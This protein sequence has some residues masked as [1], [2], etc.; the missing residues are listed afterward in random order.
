MQNWLWFVATGDTTGYHIGFT[1]VLDKKDPIQFR[2]FPKNDS[3]LD[4]VKD[5]KEL[6]QLIRFSQGFYTVEMWHD[7]LV[8]NDLRFGQIQGWE[9]PD[10][11]FVFHYFLEHPESND[12]VVQRGRMEGWNMESLR[13]YLRRIRGD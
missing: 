1:S 11:K 10:A 9:N 2:F 8:F 13:S 3:L 4:R 5:K 12:L 6:N 7:T